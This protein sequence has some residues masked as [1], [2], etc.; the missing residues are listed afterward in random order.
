MRR[1][2]GHHLHPYRDARG[3]FQFDP[4]EVRE[5]RK[6]LNRGELRLTRINFKHDPSRRSATVRQLR[7]QKPSTAF[8]TVELTPRSGA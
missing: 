1:I 8:E 3:V 6:E 2:E 4:A 7:P 5:L